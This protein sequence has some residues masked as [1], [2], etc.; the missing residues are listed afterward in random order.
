V[1]LDKEGRPL[2]S[3]P[4]LMD[5]S[6]PDECERLAALA[7]Q[8]KEL[9]ARWRE[10]QN[11]VETLRHVTHA[12]IPRPSDNSFPARRFVNIRDTVIE[13]R[14]PFRVKHANNGFN[15][16]GGVLLDWMVR[17]VG[18]KR[19]RQ[20][21]GTGSCRTARR[22]FARARSPRTSSWSRLR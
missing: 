6:Q 15:V 12:M 1:A 5:P 13:T 8:R 9:S 21:I 17:P 18:F 2:R 16:F 11:N 7:Q 19:K 14:H 10:A 4:A 22:C 3:L 20:L